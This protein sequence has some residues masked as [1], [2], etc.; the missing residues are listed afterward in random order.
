MHAWGG[1]GGGEYARHVFTHTRLASAG[2]WHVMTSRLLDCLRYI[3]VVP[4]EFRCARNN[5]VTKEH[6]GKCWQ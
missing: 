1:G 4:D 5:S 3:S 2:I 6:M